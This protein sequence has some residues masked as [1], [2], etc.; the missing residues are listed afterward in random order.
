MKTILTVFLFV[1]SLSIGYAATE[2]SSEELE[3]RAL[4]ESLC[5]GI[6]VSLSVTGGSFAIAVP[7]EQR[8]PEYPIE[9]RKVGVTGLVTVRV[10]VSEN[11]SVESIDVL[12]ANQPE[13]EASTKQAIREWTY[14][15]ALRNG[16]ACKS[17]REYQL[18]FSF[19]EE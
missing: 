3:R 17:T 1:G 6:A 10:V 7:I 8:L 11:G 19:L 12:S 4:G 5:N 16:I 14:L 15:P 18:R 2:P 13:F 9:M